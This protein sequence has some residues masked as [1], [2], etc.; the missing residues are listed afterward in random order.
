[1]DYF[2]GLGKSPA[3]KFG[4][5]IFYRQKLQEQMNLVERKRR[6]AQDVMSHAGHSNKYG[7]SDVLEAAQ[8]DTDDCESDEGDIFLR[9]EK[10]EKLV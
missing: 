3:K 8:D 2:R 7:A 6:L 4:V 1:M 5:E 9:R 10:F